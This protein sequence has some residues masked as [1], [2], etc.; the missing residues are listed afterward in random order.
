MTVKIATKHLSWIWGLH[1]ADFAVADVAA[2][3]STILVLLLLQLSAAKMR[4]E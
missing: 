3:F 4:R 2:L 1:G